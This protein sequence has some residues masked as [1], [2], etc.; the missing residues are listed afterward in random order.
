MYICDCHCDTLSKLYLDDS[1]LYENNYHFDLKRLMGIGGGLQFC[2]MYIPSEYRYQGGL[3]YAL[4]LLDKYNRELADLRGRGVDSIPILSREDAGK[5]MQHK[6]ATL[7]TIEEGGAIEGSL[8][9]LRIFY[10]L[11]VRCITLTWSNRNDIADGVNDTITGGG[12]TGFGRQV[13]RE[14]NKLGMIVDVSHIAPRGFW[15]VMEVTEKPVMATHSDAATICDVPR[16]LTDEQIRAIAAN[17]GVIGINFAT[18]FLAADPSK[19]DIDSIYRHIDHMLGLVGDDHVGFGS[20]YDGIDRTPIGAEGV[21]KFPAVLEYLA[22][23][24]YSAGTLEKIAH[25]NVFRLL[26]E[27]L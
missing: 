2:A 6:A 21:E 4:L 14:M 25:K 3:R 18:Q 22:K 12:L 8:E 15:D 17:R 13:V 9:V 24:N 26:D 27:V 1:S 5:A 16:N 23:K 10:Q 20:D 7:L 11:G 19:A